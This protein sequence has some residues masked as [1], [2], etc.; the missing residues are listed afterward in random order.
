MCVQVIING[1]HYDDLACFDVAPHREHSGAWTCESCEEPKQ[2]FP[3]AESLW[4][5]HCFEPLL[6]WA[7]E[8]LGPEMY[9]TSRRMKG[10]SYA[11][12][13][14]YDQTDTHDVD[15]VQDV[16]LKVLIRTLR[17]P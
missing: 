1:F 8:H 11:M 3:E 12:I 6:E 9:L 4:T 2:K 10:G 14:R 7:N 17:E 15:E 16:I 13:T 5:E